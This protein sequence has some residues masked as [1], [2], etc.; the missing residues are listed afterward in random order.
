MLEEDEGEREVEEKGEIE[1]KLCVVT[2]AC[3]NALD[4][5]QN[6]KLSSFTF[7][8]VFRQFIFIYCFVLCFIPFCNEQP[9]HSKSYLQSFSQS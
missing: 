6:I 1:E 5:D 2:Q 8:I 9:T 4:K 3:R 7:T